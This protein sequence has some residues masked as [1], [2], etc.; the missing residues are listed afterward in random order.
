[1]AGAHV[2]EPAAVPGER[3][4]GVELD[5]HPD[6][7]KIDVEGYEIPALR[8]ARGILAESRPLLFLEVHPG[9][10]VQLGGSLAELDALLS[11]LGY[12][13]Y[14]LKGE[15]FSRTRFAA[16]DAVSRLVCRADAGNS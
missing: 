10:I 2:E 13:Y 7:V 5:F 8:G 15:P 6:A 1:M 4:K 3:E 14:G 16:L 9:R 12:R 11:G